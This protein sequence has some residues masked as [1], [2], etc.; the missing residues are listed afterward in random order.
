MPL[1]SGDKPAA[2]VGLVGGLVLVLVMVVSIIAWTNSRFEGHTAG[3]P[4]AGAPTT[5]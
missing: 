4:A 5:H 1:H 3:A 2:F